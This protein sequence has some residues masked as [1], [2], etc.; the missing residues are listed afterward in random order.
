M[1]CLRKRGSVYY[2]QYYVGQT[3]RRVSLETSSLQIA[4]EKLR[5]LESSLAQGDAL[6]LPTRTP[7]AEI[8]AAYVRQIRLTKRPKSAQTDIYY[9]REAFGPICEELRVTSRRVTGTRRAAPKRT[10]TGTR[11]EHLIAVTYLEQVTTSQVTD[12]IAAKVRARSLAPK[13]ANRY[14]E[15]LHR[16]FAWA[17]ND[18]RVRMP[19]DRNPIT[20]VGRIPERAPEIS[21]L[22]LPQ[23]QEQLEALTGDPQLRA[24]VATLIYAGV[25]REEL[26]WLTK[27]D[28]ELGPNAG[29][30]R[31]RA[32]TIGGVAW[33]PKTRRNRAIPT[34]SDLR[35]ELS[36]YVPPA[37]RARMVLP[38][39]AGPALGSRQLLTV[40]SRR[41]RASEARVDLPRVPP[42][43][44]QPPR[45]E[46]REPLQDRNAHG[47][48]ARD[49]PETLRGAVAGVVG[50]GGGVCK[51]GD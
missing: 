36:A 5:R 25:R 27:H 3:Q 6:A 51:S 30:I 29:C 50:G 31:I 35:R 26:L 39:P 23:I 40:A 10:P 15:I 21:Y 45:D 22:T 17:I 28:V 16:L 12:F 32:K 11:R 44:R 38:E 49:L 20:R 46:G 37:V 47:Q 34:S 8:V 33:Q 2:A 18:G 9:L 41:Q 1:A 19:G 4:K 48:L 7:V 24:M 13:T 42:F 43:L 14:R